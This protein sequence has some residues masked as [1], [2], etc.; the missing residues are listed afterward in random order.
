MGT[1][2]SPFH[3]TPDIGMVP[4]LMAVEQIPIE[5][6]GLT[7]GPAKKQ[8]FDAFGNL[9]RMGLGYSNNN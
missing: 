1:L 7:Q 6:S 4:G 8:R 9:D 3:F 2:E 5:G